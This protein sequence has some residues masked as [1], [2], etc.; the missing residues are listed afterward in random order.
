MRVVFSAS[1]TL[2]L[3][4][5]A[6]L[7]ARELGAAWAS[8]EHIPVLGEDGC[9]LD[10]RSP[11]ETEGYPLPSLLPR[12]DPVLVALFDRLGG[13]MSPQ[14]ALCVEIPDDVVYSVSSHTSE[15][16]DE[17]HRVWSVHSPEGVPS[18]PTCYSF[19]KDSTFEEL[20]RRYGG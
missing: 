6:V 13:A 12:H 4:R 8:P 20:M 16:I 3:T 7:L 9:W 1:C 11:H 5:G 17:V 19:S 2:W 10:G 15:W 14:R 18:E